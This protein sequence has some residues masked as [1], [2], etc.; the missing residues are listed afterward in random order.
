MGSNSRMVLTERCNSLSNGRLS[1]PP[2]LASDNHATASLAT[3]FPRNHRNRRRRY[4]ADASHPG[5]LAIFAIT[6]VVMLLIDLGVLNRRSHAVSNKEAITWSAI[7]I[8][9]AMIFSGSST[10][11]LAAIK[12]LKSFRSFSP[13][14][15][16]KRHSRWTIFCV[17]PGV[18]L[19]QCAARGP[20]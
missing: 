18:Q 7:W 6:I 16:S 8:S 14:I 11:K 17:H 3:R 1:S 12:A 9:L 13:V 10:T 4:G 20:P 15:G 2:I 5:L 19:F